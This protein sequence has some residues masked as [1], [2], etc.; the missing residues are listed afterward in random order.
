MAGLSGF[1]SFLQA[2]LFFFAFCQKSIENVKKQQNKYKQRTFILIFKDSKFRNGTLNVPPL[3][4][5]RSFFFFFVCSLLHNPFF[6]DCLLM[7][8]VTEL[9]FFGLHVCQLSTGAESRV[10]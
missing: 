4:F 7:R 10:S 1:T 8:E 3:A 9:G 2:F 6:R 5:G